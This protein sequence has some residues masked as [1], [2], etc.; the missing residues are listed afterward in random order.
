MTG[1]NCE[2]GVGGCHVVAAWQALKREEPS[3][4]L[5][6]EACGAV[7]GIAEV[8]DAGTVTTD[9]LA[10]APVATTNYARY[11]VYNAGLSALRSVVALLAV[12]T[13]LPLRPEPCR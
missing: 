3:L 9:A 13:I 11:W 8:A 5:G 4:T 7:S 2:V 12:R 10:A 6:A 1:A